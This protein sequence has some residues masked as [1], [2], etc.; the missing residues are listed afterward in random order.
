MKDNRITRELPTPETTGKTDEFI[1]ESGLK[2]KVTYPDH[3]PD[4]VRR[5]KINRLYDI[6]SGTDRKE[7]AS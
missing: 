5:Q 2:I 7:S 6:L 3:V 4:A 1:S